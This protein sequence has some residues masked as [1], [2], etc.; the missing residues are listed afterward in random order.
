MFWQNLRQSLKHLLARR[1]SGGRR[2]RPRAFNTLLSLEP[3]EQR[4]LLAVDLSLIGSPLAENGGTAFVVA[5]LDTASTASV[6]VTLDL[7]GTAIDGTD[8][9]ASGVVIVIGAGDTTGSV[10]VTSLTD[11]LDEP[12]ETIEVTIANIVGDVNGTSTSVTASITDDD[13]PPT[14]SLSLSSTP[15]VENAGSSAV[16]ATLSA[17]SGQTVTVNLLNSGTANSTSDYSLSSTQIIFNPGQT[18][19][20]VSL[21]SLNDTTDE[22]DETVILDIDTVQNGTENGTQQVTAT[23]TDDDNAPAVSL[24]LTGSPLA[25]NGGVATVIATLSNPSSQAVVVSLDFTGTATS[26]SDY[27]FSTTSITIAAGQTSGSISITSIDD[28]TD[29]A[30]ETVIVDITGVTNGTENGTQQVTATITDDDSSPQVS[31]ALLNS[32][33]AE[34]GGVAQV[35]ATLSTTSSQAVVVTLGFTGTATS[36]SDYNVSTTSITIAAGQT[37]GSISITSIDDASDE[38]NETVIIDITGVTNGTEN[39]TQQVTATITDDD[40]SPTV[41]L[42]LLNS[43][44]AENGGVAQVIATLSATSAQDVIV[45]LGFTGTATSGSDYNIST[46]SITI[47]AGQ[48]SGSISITSINDASDEAN[49]TVIVDIAGVTNGTENG[50]QQ[51][52]AT[53]TDDDNPPEVTLSLLNSPLAENGGVAQVVATLSAPSSNNVTVN[54]GFAGTASSSDYSLSSTSIIILAGQTSGSISIL[55]INDTTDEAN[56]SIVVDITSLTGATENG[57][58]Q[59]VA[60]INDDDNAPT[61]SLSVNNGQIVENAGIAHVIAT[62][63]NPSSQNVTIDLVF[64]GTATSGSDYSLSSTSIVISAGQTSGS[65]SITSIQDGSILEGNETVVVDIGNVTN[66]TENGTQQV[67]TIIQDSS[68]PTVSISAS[69]TTIGELATSSST[70]IATLSATSAQTTTVNLGFT[71][72]ANSPLDYTASSLSIVIPAGSLT[73]SISVTSISDGLDEDNETIIVSIDSVS[74]NANENGAQ[75]V[76]V[77]IADDDPVP[78][79]T[80][81]AS[82]TTLAENT[83]SS[84]SIIAFLNAP[85]GRDVTVFFDNATGATA[86]P[87]VDYTASGF[88]GA[89][90]SIT[91]PAGQTSGSISLTALNDTLDEANETILVHVLNVT[92]GAPSGVQTQTITITD[93]DAPPTVTFSTSATTLAEN[94]TA[95]TVTATL[96]VISGQAVTISL[97]ATGT[98]N[99]PS[100]YQLG[101][102]GVITIPAGSLTGSIT[103]SPTQDVLVEGNE[104]IILNIASTTN[105]DFNSSVT[106]TVTLTDDE[107]TG[108]PVIQ[109]LTTSET[110]S[111]GSIAQIVVVLSQARTESTTVTLNPSGSAT[112]GSDYTIAGGVTVTIPAGQTSAA[113]SVNVLN[114]SATEPNETITLTL[115]GPSAGVNLGGNN[116]NTLTIPANTFSNFVQNGNVLNVTGTAG[117]DNFQLLFTSDSTFQINFNGTSQTFSTANVAFVYFDGLGGNDSALITGSSAVE[118]LVLAQNTMSMTGA[119]FYAQTLNTEYNTFNGNNGQGVSDVAYLFDTVGDDIFAATQDTSLMYTL[120]GSAVTYYNTVFNVGTVVAVSNAGGNDQASFGDTAGND[121][122]YA[123]QTYAQLQNSAGSA[124]SLIQAQGFNFVLFDAS[125]GTD[126]VLFDDTA[127][128]GTFYGQAGNSALVGGMSTIVALDADVVVASSSGIGGTAVLTGSAS[129]ADSLTGNPAALV[130]QIATTSAFY[131]NNFS[132]AYVFGQGGGDIANIGDTFGDDDFYGMQTTFAVDSVANYLQGV[133]FSL[134]TVTASG[135][136]DAAYF[137]DSTGDDTFEGAPQLSSFTGSGYSLVANNFFTVAAQF[138]SGSDVARLTGSNGNDTFVGS[139]TAAAL[140]GADYSLSVLGVD[141][142]TVRAL[143]GTDTASLS[144]S[145]GSDYLIAVGSTIDLQYS[146]GEIRL[147]GFDSTVANSSKGGIDRKTTSGTD[148]VLTTTGNW[149]TF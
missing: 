66:G 46:S 21:V 57:T 98:A 52:T 99:S 127:G 65:I 145:T 8:Y 20:S 55:G 68:L 118:T 19:G 106:Q 56:E 89:T 58:Q 82:Q 104:T 64:T 63:S 80:I 101:N 45:A 103:L 32:P 44:L 15:L 140:A 134:V 143:L 7:G 14:V 110:S 11:D 24:S 3:L 100:D 86:T 91:I 10:S 2:S 42:S 117:D 88:S 26:G 93:D 59:V 30:N 9:S 69:T 13:A 144:D 31:L 94:G 27:N 121:S 54:L 147:I 48:T 51:V 38:A 87:N 90:F 73:G 16:I 76:T 141:D 72:T 85:S 18:I 4:R 33:L 36:G 29:E 39:G 84:T 149:L 97:G 67:T 116:I 126:S 124:S 107:S 83:S 92:N 146:A 131:L 40:G 17:P 108:T 111:E 70:I 102:G 139:P 23:I 136:G 128:A 35:V 34:N 114:D 148:A 138:S 137:Y 43:P 123:A 74:S 130:F 71:G 79:V 22:P 5:T 49:E 41:S 142:L 125:T 133:G 95:L 25:E 135:T 96:S 129:T 28:A 6:T 37:S 60:T 47:T 78:T 109:F 115:T 119:N 122:F 75:S 1:K 53:I 77:T 61:V 50:T 120:N 112:S 12:D 81:S 105:A 113:I 62:L 132:T